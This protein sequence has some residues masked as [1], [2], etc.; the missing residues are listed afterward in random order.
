MFVHDT[1]LNRLKRGCETMAYPKGPAPALPDRHGGALQVEAAKCADG[2]AA[3]VPVCP[4]EAIFA[5][6]DVPEKWKSCIAMNREKVAGAAQISVKK[7]A[8]GKD[9][10]QC[11]PG[12]K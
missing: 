10:P 8:L 2:C 3:C 12:A 1:L 9:K 7:E 4:I 11:K 5:E 6:A